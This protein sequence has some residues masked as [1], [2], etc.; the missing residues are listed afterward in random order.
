MKN[1]KIAYIG[2]GSRGWAWGLM[3]D[4]AAESDISGS[5]MLYDIDCNAAKSN[6]I[7]GNRFSGLEGSRSAW[8]YKTAPTLEEALYGADFV[9]ISILPATFLEMASDVH[10][11]EKYG[12]YQP[13]GDTVGPGGLVRALRTIP[14]Y[15][16]IAASIKQYSPNAWVI[17]YTN[18]MTLCLR[19][20]YKVFP[21]IRAIGCCH[22]VFGTQELLMEALKEQEG[23]CDITREDIH[24]NVLGINHFTWIDHAAYRNYDL[25]PV[26]SDFVEKY[27]KTG[28]LIN[29]GDQTLNNYFTSSNRVKFDLFRRYGLIAAAGDRHLAEFLPSIYIR[30]PETVEKWGFTLTPVD[31]RIENKRELEARAQRLVSGEESP[32]IRKTGEEGVSQIKALL[33]LGNLTTNVN[34]PNHGQMPDAPIGAVV[35]TNAVFAYDCVKPVANGYLPSGVNSL[36]L[37]HI[38]NQENIL[39]GFFTEDRRLLFS[40][41]MEYLAISLENGERLFAEMLEN[42]KS[43][44]PE[45]LF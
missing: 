12:I 39:S 13:V 33:G 32:V 43:Y 6:E 16:D 26:Y 19:T 38:M 3:S 9:I 29:S 18:P 2:G 23:V 17:N 27:Y 45:W 20:L 11:P 5:V 15:V 8:E 21:G 4:L 42:T 34:Y 25:F 40:C 10:L 44:L 1:I 22:E 35:E 36:I 7:I 24:V 31:W 37:K 28:F 30:D 14:L 41:F